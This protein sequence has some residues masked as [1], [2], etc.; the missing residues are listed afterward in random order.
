MWNA[1]YVKGWHC[2]WLAGRFV[3]EAATGPLHHHPPPT[4][5]HSNTVIHVHIHVHSR[6]QTD[7]LSPLERQQRK[8]TLTTTHKRTT[9]AGS[10]RGW[11]D[12][13]HDML[14]LS[15][16]GQQRVRK[17]LPGAGELWQRLDTLPEGFVGCTHVESSAEKPRWVTFTTYWDHFRHLFSRRAKVWLS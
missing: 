17:N 15:A 3:W 9:V 8:Q 14:P 12:V 2:T 10:R 1:R 5:A 16:R 4:P 11:R 13:E 7:R 6:S